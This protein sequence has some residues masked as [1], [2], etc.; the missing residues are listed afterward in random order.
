MYTTNTIMHTTNTIMHT[1]N[2][3]LNM[4]IKTFQQFLLNVRYQCGSVHFQ[5]F[6]SADF[7]HCEPVRQKL[8][9]LRHV[10]L[11]LRWNKTNTSY[12]SHSSQP[13]I[14]DRSLRPVPAQENT[15]W[16]R[17]RKVFPNKKI[18]TAYDGLYASRR[19]PFRTKRLTVEDVFESWKLTKT[20]DHIHEHDSVTQQLWDRTMH[21][22][23][24]GK[25]CT[26]T[27]KMHSYTLPLP[28]HLHAIQAPPTHPLTVDPV[29][30]T[31]RCSGA[32]LCCPDVTSCSF[33]LAFQ[34][35]Q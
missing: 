14:I 24:I 12:R 16:P 31:H 21:I 26:H 8:P 22:E 28:S 15:C 2:T 3:Q 5:I 34:W 29:S 11:D 33:L 19:P 27:H 20:V 30:F 1:T 10:F 25:Q 35:R 23:I 13:H 4:I 9:Q 18:T 17:H 7:N 32:Y 6:T